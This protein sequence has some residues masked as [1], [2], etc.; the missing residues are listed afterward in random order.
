MIVKCPLICQ[1]KI[2]Q[3]QLSALRV[4]LVLQKCGLDQLIQPGSIVGSQKVMNPNEEVEEMN[5]FTTANTAPA[6]HIQPGS[7]LPFEIISQR[8]TQ[9]R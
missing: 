9:L 8:L 2:I 7:Q 4:C 1:L 6:S 3:S 5:E